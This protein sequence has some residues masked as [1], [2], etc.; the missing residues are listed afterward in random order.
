MH[1]FIGI[2]NVGIKSVEFLGIKN[3]DAVGGTAACPA[4]DVERKSPSV[5]CFLLLLLFGL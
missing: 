5:W 1:S 3:D 4:L 2:R